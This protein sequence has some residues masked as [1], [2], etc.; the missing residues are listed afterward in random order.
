M[1]TDIDNTVLLH[2]RALG[3]FLCRPVF[4]ALHALIVL[5]GQEGVEQ[6]DDEVFMLAEHFLESQVGFRV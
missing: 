2:L 4:N 6:T 3:N 5:Q 1:A